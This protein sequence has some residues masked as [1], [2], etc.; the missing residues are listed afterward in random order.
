M[1]LH[2]LHKD[3]KQESIPGGYAPTPAFLVLVGVCV[4]GADPTHVRPLPQLEADI[5]WTMEA[6]LTGGR[7]PSRCWSCDL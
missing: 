3:W 2:N 7:P 1:G 4:Q 6:D 5:L